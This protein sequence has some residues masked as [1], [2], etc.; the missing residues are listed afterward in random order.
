MSSIFSASR[1][2]Q[3]CS[4]D[5]TNSEPVTQAYAALGINQ[6]DECSGKYEIIQRV[7]GLSL[8][9]NAE[10]FIPSAL[11]SGSPYG[12]NSLASQLSKDT[13]GKKSLERSSSTK[14]NG[15]NDEHKRYWPF[16]LP[17]DLITDFDIAA[18]NVLEENSSYEQ[19]YGSVLESY[20]AHGNVIGLDNSCDVGQNGG[21]EQVAQQSFSAQNSPL[22]R[23]ERFNTAQTSSNS[24]LPF[25]SV[26]SPYGLASQQL[27][28][29]EQPLISQRDAQFFWGEDSEADYQSDFAE[30][31]TYNDLGDMQMLAIEFPNFAVESLAEI[32]YANHGDLMLT[33]E[34]LTQLEIQEG[35]SQQH[36]E[37][38]TPAA[39]SLSAMDFPALSGFELANG[40]SPSGGA[41]DIQPNSRQRRM[42]L[43]NTFSHTHGARETGADFAAIV[44]K[45]AEQHAAPWQYQRNGGSNISVGK[46]VQNLR[47]GDAAGRAGLEQFANAN[48]RDLER[49][50]G[51]PW[52]ETGEAVAS[53]YSDMREEARDHARVRNAYFEQ[54][55][56]AY[57][58]GN[59][60]LA[61]ELSAKGQWH[62]EQ[63]KAAHSKAG[64]AI[65]RQRN[66]SG[67]FAHSF[68][69]GQPRLLDLHGLHVNEAILLLK[70]ELATLKLSARSTSKRQ[71]VFIC[72]GTGHHTK[73]SRTPARL[74]AAIERY[75]LEEEHLQFTET[76]PGMLRV[77]L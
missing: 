43:S 47:T 68:K 31:Q 51:Q 32:L 25:N 59:K 58:V 46:S 15:S 69:Q 8:N 60:A 75:L 16:Q 23:N 29:T 66:T 24:F 18:D 30:Q 64:E 2:M 57:L 22:A 26:S 27:L 10:E 48:I 73:G 19:S 50:R 54:A 65:F 41:A 9:P 44:R 13:Y 17:D 35:V 12:E 74:P 3:V 52:L 70:R 53:I 72:V 1:E 67:T 56:Q 36:L 49:L 62:N 39:P 4:V 28:S 71:Q 61:K 42:E 14:S 38:A 5:V 55:R 76:Q 63:M 45:H 6:R 77:V 40:I 20:G 7:G 34:M 33:I 11:R 37:P 21:A